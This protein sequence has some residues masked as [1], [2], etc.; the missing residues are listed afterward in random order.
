MEYNLRR[1]GARKPPGLA[2][3]LV[4]PKPGEGQRKA[5]PYSP[6]DL[7]ALWATAHSQ[8]WQAMVTLNPPPL[9]RIMEWPLLRS[10]LAK[11]KMTLSNWHRRKGFPGVIVV[12]EF[13]PAGS[14]DE[15]CANFHLGFVSPL[16]E[17]QQK[18]FSDWWLALWGLNDNRGHAFHYDAKGGGSQLQDYLGKDVSFRAGARRYVKFHAKWLPERIE[19]RLWFVI[20]VKRKPA[21]EGALLRGRR[22]L[23]RRRFDSEHAKTPATRLTESTRTPDSEHALTYITPV[24]FSQPI[25]QSGVTPVLE[26]CH[27]EPRQL[28]PVCWR[29]RG[30]S[31][32]MGAC[33]C[34]D[35][36]PFT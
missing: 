20:G 16:S 26:L 25:A 14:S 15:I 11:L 9:S 4:P 5:R 19:N 8:D 23:R 17:E 27:V 35:E 18:I 32:W 3:A 29:S 28:C 22:G 31:L 6:R 34:T 13:D 33:K 7:D 36:F 30:R 2:R 21:R 1:N 12:T 24:A 10:S